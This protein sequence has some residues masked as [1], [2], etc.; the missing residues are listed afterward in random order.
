M[1]EKKKQRDV[2]HFTDLEVWRRSHQL[3]LDLIIDLDPLPRKRSVAILTDQILRSVGSVGAN[4][5]EGFNRS[6]KKYLNSLDIALGEADEAENWLY[7]LRD[8]GFLP[9]DRADTHIR[10]CI[11]IEKMLNGLMRS[12]RRSSD[13]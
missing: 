13:T 9:R 5:A 2:K 7:K 12:I 4:I 11:E 3:F 1:S 8:A 10:E 6:K